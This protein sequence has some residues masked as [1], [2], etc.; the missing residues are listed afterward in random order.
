MA[1]DDIPCRRIILVRHGHYERTGGLGDTAWGLSPLGRRQAVRAGR[2]LAQIV[3]SSTA[4]FDGLFA[5]PWPRA[6]QTAEIAA[7]ELDLHSV[8]I[9]PWLHEVVPVVDPARVDFGPLPLGLE[10][11]PPEERAIAHQQIEKVRE[12]FFK[13]PRRASLVLLFTHGNLIRFL[14][15]R[16]LRLPYEAWAMMDIAH[17]G[18]TELRVYGSGFEALVSFNETGHLPPPL[19]TT[20]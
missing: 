8:K 7:H 5:S 15:A 19:I 2:R 20:A 1:D 6:S 11:T 9:K 4:R 10:T 16:T 13:A 18:I 14:V 12:R 17:S 3:A